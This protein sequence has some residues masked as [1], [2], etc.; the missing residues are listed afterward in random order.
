MRLSISNCRPRPQG[1]TV[2]L[3]NYEHEAPGKRPGAFIDDDEDLL[4]GPECEAINQRRM[5]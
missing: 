5:L 2:G 1:K 4:T 3:N